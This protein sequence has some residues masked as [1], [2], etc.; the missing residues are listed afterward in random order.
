MQDDFKTSVQSSPSVASALAAAL[1]AEASAILG[2]TTDSV[3]IP[4]GMMMAFKGRRFAVSLSPLPAADPESDA[5]A[6]PVAIDFPP[7]DPDLYMVECRKID[8]F[9][10]GLD[11]DEGH[12]DESPSDRVKRVLRFYAER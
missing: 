4:P 2:I 10:D 8:A 1:V 5:P 12:L 3:D 11:P 7:P 6:K 9:L